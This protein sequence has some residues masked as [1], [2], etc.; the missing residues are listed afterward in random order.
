MSIEKYIKYMTLTR[1]YP[2]AHI[3]VKCDRQSDFDFANIF[4]F[5]SINLTAYR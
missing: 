4:K 2:R 1:I 3:A 5:N